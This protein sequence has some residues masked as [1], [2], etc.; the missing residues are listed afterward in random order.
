MKI[1]TKTNNKQT[2]N[3]NKQKGKEHQS[4]KK[5][6]MS[7]LVSALNEIIKQCQESQ[8]TSGR[9]FSKGESRDWVKYVLM[10]IGKKR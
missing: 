4:K 9:F 3:K 10:Q 1:I 7:E 6:K 5:K 2:T 8:E